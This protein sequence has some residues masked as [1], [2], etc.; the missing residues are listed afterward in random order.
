MDTPACR[1]ARH[2]AD[3]RPSATSL[4]YDIGMGTDRKVFVRGAD[5]EELGEDSDAR[6]ESRTRGAVT[7]AWQIQTTSDVIQIECF[8]RGELVRSLMYVREGGRWSQQGAAQPF[9]SKALGAWL[10]KKKLLA[11]PDGYDVLE[12]F[13]GRDRPPRTGK[14]K[15]K[16]RGANQNLYVAPAI[17]D[18]LRGLA[19]RRGVT[20]SALLAA[21]WELGKHAL[22]DRIVPEAT[23]APD[24]PTVAQAKPGSAKAV[25]FAHERRET[26]A[27]E[28]T[29][30]PI[31]CGFVI[32]A[33]M[34]AEIV[35]MARIADRAMSW[36]VR[37]AYV[38]ARPQLV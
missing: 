34:R 7:V 2:H 31:E 20:A 23:D 14:P 32:D 3:L 9:E 8:D 15:I 25:A 36:I 19:A 5:W 10:K 16:D 29:G 33:E 38:L 11:S 13:L 1:S 17:V 37:E 26:N 27:I 6:A 21:A 18:E 4:R 35:A 12:C 24:G 28:T 22:Y 30:D